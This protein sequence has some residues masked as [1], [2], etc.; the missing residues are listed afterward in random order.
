MLSLSLLLRVL[1]PAALPPGRSVVSDG[2]FQAA[3]QAI[4]EDGGRG[5]GRNDFPALTFARMLRKLRRVLLEGSDTEGCDA[6]RGLFL[7]PSSLKFL[8]IIQ[9]AGVFA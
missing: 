9:Q 8:P 7:L 3:A 2:A 4:R 5:F 1:T 6:M